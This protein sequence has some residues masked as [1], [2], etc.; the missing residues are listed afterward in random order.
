MAVY[1]K[2]VSENSLASSNG[3]IP[4]WILL[5]INGNN[6]NN[7]LDLQFYAAEPELI[8]ELQDKKG[9]QT[10]IEIEN[11][12]ESNLGIEIRAHSCRTCCNKC[13]FCFVD[14][15]PP[16]MRNSLYVKDDD[17]VFSFVY[18][19]FI[20][21]TNLTTTEFER[22]RNQRISPLYVSV[23]TTNPA[24]HKKMLRYQL[25]FNIM[26]KLQQL[27]AADI[28]MHT[29]VVVIPG[30]NDG[31]ELQR[32]LQQLTQLQVLSVGIV[33]VGLTKF[34]QQLPKIRNLNSKEAQA[35]LQ[36]S[37]K[38]PN[39][40]C[41]DE[42]YLLADEKLP[43]TEFY[44]D[45]PQLENGIGMIRLLWD[46]WQANKQNFLVDIN[47]SSDKLVFITGKLVAPY[48]QKIVNEINNPFPNKARLKAV[49]NNFFG[50]TVTVTGLLTATD[51]LQQIELVED[52][53]A[54]FSSNLFNPDNYTLDGMSQ[55]EL[56]EKLGG[57]LLV[58]DE[59][60]ADWK[61]I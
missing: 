47:E 18:G 28:Q 40:F 61:F 20:T 31:E 29:Q 13:V 1:I 8:V 60:F 32:T 2:Q 24:L 11:D 5:K 41:S 3:I 12:Y 36:L 38:Y 27:A 46:N 4:G 43:N 16:N 56:K 50:Q 54:V 57:K 7:F 58:V 14:Q 30:W 33:P 19:N 39:V 37:K 26:E 10:I 59:E 51:I 17:Y 25:D 48:I 35:I 42:I 45:F 44:E 6:I 9:N 49:A 52:E 22:I 15:M 55:K 23:H 53:I 21:L 34:R